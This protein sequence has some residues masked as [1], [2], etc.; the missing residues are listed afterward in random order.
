MKEIDTHF[1]SNRDGLGDCNFDLVK[2]QHDVYLYHRTYMDRKHLSY[3]VFISKFIAKGTPLPGG[4]FEKEDR[5]K[6]PKKNDFGK[7]AYECKDICQAE[8]RFDELLIKFKQKSDNKE[9]SLKTGTVVKGRRGR[10]RHE[11][12]FQLPSIDQT[13]TMNQLVAS[14]GVSQPLLYIRVQELIS[15]GRVKEYSRVRK[16]GQRG[17]ATVVYQVIA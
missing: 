8:D 11:F 2:K 17:R 3:E 14:S 13:F 10:K 9:L 12:K 6:Y 5:M 16:E 4:V 15:L 1:V 7:T